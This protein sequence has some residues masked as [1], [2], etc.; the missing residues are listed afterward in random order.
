MK[1]FI[2]YIFLIGFIYC[3][4]SDNKKNY[5]QNFLDKNQNKK[6][7]L[8]FENTRDVYK[9]T[10]EAIELI[11]MIKNSVKLS[12]KICENIKNDNVSITYEVIKINEYLNCGKDIKK[13]TKF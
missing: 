9:S 2:K 1:N 10:K 4:I 7:G 12:E 3:A 5:I 13:K 11:N 6:N 8:F